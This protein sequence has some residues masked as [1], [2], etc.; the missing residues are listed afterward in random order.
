MTLA[1]DKV[2]QTQPKAL[3]QQNEEHTEMQEVENCDKILSKRER[4]E[5]R[6]K[7]M[8]KTEKKDKHLEENGSTC[9][10]IK[11][12]QKG[13]CKKR[14]DKGEVSAA[15]HE[16]GKRKREDNGEAFTKGHEKEKRKKEKIMQKFLQK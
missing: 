3:E 4:K 14:E 6:R 10:G 13:K 11:D 16:K 8:H 2:N 5:D 15:G 12:K 9:A 7:K 1:P